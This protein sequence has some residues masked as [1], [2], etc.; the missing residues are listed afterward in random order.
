MS[1]HHDMWPGQESHIGCL[2]QTRQGNVLSLLVS[3]R[4]W[5]QVF[6]IHRRWFH[7]NR[8]SDAQ[9]LLEEPL[10]CKS[11][12]LGL[13]AR[14]SVF[15]CR[16]K[17]CPFPAVRISSVILVP[18]S[19]KGTQASD[20]HCN[21]RPRRQRANDLHKQL[22]VG[23]ATALDNGDVSL[24]NCGSFASLRPTR[25]TLRQQACVT[26]VLMPS[27]SCCLFLLPTNTG[28]CTHVRTHGPSG[29]WRWRHWKGSAFQ[30]GKTGGSCCAE[31]LQHRNKNIVTQL[32]S[33]RT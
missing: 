31:C 7:S 11:T 1:S 24:P 32:R 2:V 28:F 4:Q 15:I 14:Q 5:S 3:N 22:S 33:A 26:S 20:T 21:T 8:C 16:S 10:Q 19:N 30:S 29:Q 17:H 6:P 9:P 13:C 23:L 12:W 18:W 25:T 27:F